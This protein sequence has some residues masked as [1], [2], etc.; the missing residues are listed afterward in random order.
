M[1]EDPG[2]KKDLLQLEDPLLGPRITLALYLVT[3][4][5]PK[6]PGLDGPGWP[7]EGYSNWQAALF[8]ESGS[9]SSV[10]WSCTWCSE[11]SAA[12]TSSPRNRPPHSPHHL[13]TSQWQVE[14]KSLGCFSSLKTNS[15]VDGRDQANEA[16]TISAAA[17]HYPVTYRQPADHATSPSS[18]FTSR[19]SPHC[20]LPLAQTPTP[21]TSCK[22]CCAKF[23]TIFI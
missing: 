20:C 11:S 15:R 12:H 13:P 16:G 4:A 8:W 23:V 6:A 7:A 10:D 9:G 18:F 19:L 21:P 2:L 14:N 1:V 3:R 22:H 5:M 17:F